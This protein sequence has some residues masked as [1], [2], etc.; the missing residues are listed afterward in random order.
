MKFTKEHGIVRARV[1]CANPQSIPNRFDH[2][3]DG[4]GFSIFFEIEF[5]DGSVVPT[6]TFDFEDTSAAGNGKGP[7][8]GG[9]NNG[10]DNSSPPKENKSPEGN[11]EDTMQHN[12]VEK[13][14]DGMHEMHIGEIKISYMSPVKETPSSSHVLSPKSESQIKR[15]SSTNEVVTNSSRSSSLGEVGTHQGA[16]HH[17]VQRF[18]LTA[19]H[20]ASLSPISAAAEN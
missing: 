13:T 17:N 20:R 5:P 18:R 1:D 15:L 3:Y 4:E 2:H 19:V 9:D 8:D 12:Q 7:N 16:A 10:N 11:L 6:G 14:S